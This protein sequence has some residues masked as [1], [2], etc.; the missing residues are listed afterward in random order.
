M[1]NKLVIRA[2]NKCSGIKICT[3]NVKD[4][5]RIRIVPET[6]SDIETGSIYFVFDANNKLVEIYMPDFL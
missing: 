5:K 1:N 3:Y 4:R 2:L 6:S